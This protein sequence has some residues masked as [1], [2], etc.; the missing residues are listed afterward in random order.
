M[1]TENINAAI[2][3]LNAAKARRAAAG[4][5]IATAAPAVAKAVKP[6]RQAA[7]PKV[8]PAGALPDVKIKGGRRAARAALT[9]S[10]RELR[11]EQGVIAADPKPEQA[12]KVQDAL[13]ANGMDQDSP[14]AEAIAAAVRALPDTSELVAPAGFRYAT[15]RLIKGPRIAHKDTT[16]GEV[17]GVGVAYHVWPDTRVEG[18]YAKRLASTTLTAADLLLPVAVRQAPKASGTRRLP[19]ARTINELRTECRVALADQDAGDN[20]VTLNSVKVTGTLA[21]QLRSAAK[22]LGID[23]ADFRRVALQRLAAEVLALDNAAGSEP[24]AH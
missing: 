21:T 2:Q 3:Q 20:L 11:Q 18:G 7:V 17:I 5:V 9:T 14:G 1:R 19:A 13:V 22:A 4:Q 12:A 8:E 10:L 6:A 16:T 15:P 24:A 23:V